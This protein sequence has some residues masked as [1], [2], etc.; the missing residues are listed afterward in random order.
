VKWNV[1][2]PSQHMGLVVVG[3]DASDPEMRPTHVGP[4]RGYMPDP[5][6]LIEVAPDNVVSWS[7]RICRL[8]TSEEAIEYWRQRAVQAEIDLQGLKR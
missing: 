1:D 4:M 7:V 2:K 6:V 3:F 5:T 8:A